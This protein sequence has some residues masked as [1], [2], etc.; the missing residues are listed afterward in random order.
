MLQNKFPTSLSE[1]YIKFSL[2]L[3]AEGMWNVLMK[4]KEE[5]FQH[6]FTDLIHA[7]NEI[8][9]FNYTNIQME[10]NK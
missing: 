1:E 2:A 5:D 10:Y 3:N 9:A 7:F 4:W 6:S 8:A